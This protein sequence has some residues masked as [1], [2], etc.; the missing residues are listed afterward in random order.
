MFEPAPPL[1]PWAPVF[2]TPP[3]SRLVHNKWW[4][5]LSTDLAFKG[6]PFVISSPVTVN[7]IVYGDG[8]YTPPEL[9]ALINGVTKT[10]MWSYTRQYGV[11]NS[12][13]LGSVVV[14]GSNSSLYVGAKVDVVALIAS[15]VNHEIFEIAPTSYVSVF[16][17]QGIDDGGDCQYCAYHSSFHS[18]MTLLTVPNPTNFLYQVVEP[19]YPAPLGQCGCDP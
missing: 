2:E 1:P 11:T 15:V 6:G 13:T 12:V 10:P 7:V 8:S 4:P 19:T 9:Q 17:S 5:F 16:L 18:N 3:S 14:V